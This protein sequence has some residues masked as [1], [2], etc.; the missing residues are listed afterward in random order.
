MGGFLPQCLP[1]LPCRQ[2][3]P[4]P[5]G[6]FPTPMPSSAAVPPAHALP[7]WVVSYPN[8]ARGAREGYYA[9]EAGRVFSAMPPLSQ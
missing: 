5:N 3:T 1:P 2:R 4:Y 8:A 7:Q 9:D 6:R